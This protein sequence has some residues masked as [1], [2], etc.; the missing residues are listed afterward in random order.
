M[1]NDICLYACN[2]TVTI[3]K[4]LS[5]EIKPGWKKGTKITF[6]EKGNVQLGVVVADLVFVIDG[7]PHDLFRREGNDL[8]LVQKISLDEALIGFS[9]AII[10]WEDTK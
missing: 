3:Q 10:E 9:I 1:R 7:R 2:K 5:T 8:V 4:V 6:P